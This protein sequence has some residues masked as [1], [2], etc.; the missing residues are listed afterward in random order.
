MK[1]ATS[2]RQ[3]NV[4]MMTGPPA[5]HNHGGFQELCL[6]SQQSGSDA[7]IYKMTSCLVGSDRQSTALVLGLFQRNTKIPTGRNKPN[8]KHCLQRELACKSGKCC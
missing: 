4:Y 2:C 7:T 5:R 1:S 3:S 8:T 6:A